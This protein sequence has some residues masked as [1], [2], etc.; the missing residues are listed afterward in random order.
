VKEWFFKGCW[1]PEKESE[2]TA[3]PKKEGGGVVVVW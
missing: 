3:G 2:R 1:A